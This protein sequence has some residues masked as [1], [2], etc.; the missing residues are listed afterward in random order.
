MYSAGWLTTLFVDPVTL[1]LDGDAKPTKQWFQA[2]TP[3]S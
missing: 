3:L 1:F 2:F